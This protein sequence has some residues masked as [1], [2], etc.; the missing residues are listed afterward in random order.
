MKLGIESLSSRY[1]CS[2]LVAL[3]SLTPARLRPV[4]HV[5]RGCF[6]DSARHLLAYE[7]L[8][9]EVR[10][11][12]GFVLLVFFLSRLPPVKSKPQPKRD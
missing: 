5:E 7:S 1:C 3:V 10:S 6:T 8:S 4:D 2:L 9:L 12:I 11:T